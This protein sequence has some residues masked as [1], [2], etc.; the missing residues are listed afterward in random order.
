MTVDTERNE[1]LKMCKLCIDA[2]IETKRVRFV[3]RKDNRYVVAGLEDSRGYLFKSY[4]GGRK[5]FSIEG[6]K[7]AGVENET[8]IR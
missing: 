2:A 6:A 7:I 4:P 5:M 8:G 3:I 1:F